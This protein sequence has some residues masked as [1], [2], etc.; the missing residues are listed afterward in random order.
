MEKHKHYFIE[1]FSG[2]EYERLTKEEK[3]LLEKRIKRNKLVFWLIFILLM[4]GISYL[5]FYA[6]FF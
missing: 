5:I 3:M 1:D 4:S 2:T 6:G